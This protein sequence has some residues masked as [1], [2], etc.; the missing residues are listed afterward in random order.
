MGNRIGRTRRGVLWLLAAGPVALLTRAQPPGYPPE[1]QLPYPNPR[2]ENPRLPNG[3]LQKDA[4]AQDDHKQA[5]KETDRLIATAQQLKAELEKAG[6][7]VVPL[8][9]VR[10]TEEIERL[11]KKIRGK[12]KD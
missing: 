3:K 2:N 7:Y 1:P 6:A 9:A 10:K 12:L 5:L 8:S 11:A 4:I